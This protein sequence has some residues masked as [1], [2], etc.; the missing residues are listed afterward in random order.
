MLSL[1]LAVVVAQAE[2]YLIGWL[3]L[4]L[5]F[6]LCQIGWIFVVPFS[7]GL[8]DVPSHVELEVVPSSLGLE[9]VPSHVE[10]EVVPFSLGLQ[11][12]PSHVELEVVPSSLGLEDVPSHMGHL[13]MYILDLVEFSLLFT[14]FIEFSF[15][16]IVKLGLFS[17]DLCFYFSHDLCF[18]FSH[19]LCFY[20][21]HDLCFYFSH[22]LCFYFSH[23]LGFYAAS[24]IHITKAQ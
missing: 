18:Y 19:D 3:G 14:H 21:S 11:D 16:K 12:V 5:L 1:C 7:L 10:L 9:D 4:I 6:F 2:Q 8:Q 20:F 13:G 15:L 17:H 23:D 24:N 22:D